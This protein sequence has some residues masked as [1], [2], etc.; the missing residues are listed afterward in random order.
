MLR[1]WSGVV[2][3][4]HWV[5]RIRGWRAELRG[6]ALTGWPVGGH[7]SVLVC[8]KGDCV[9]GRLLTEVHISI[10]S[11]HSR[12]TPSWTRA[13]KQPGPLPCRSCDS[14]A[15]G[16]LQR[17][18]WSAGGRERTGAGRRGWSWCVLREFASRR[19]SVLVTPGSHLVARTMLNDDPETKALYSKEQALH[20]LS[21][22]LRFRASDVPACVQVPQAATAEACLGAWASLPRMPALV[23]RPDW[24]D[25]GW[26]AA[27]WVVHGVC[28]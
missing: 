28:I 21:R 9:Q 10:G 23:A 20:T 12:D 8:V 7:R 19:R 3:A 26:I 14:T 24:R 2:L 5:T 11:R 22:Q 27:G 25:A 1:K 4:E 6:S 18:W 16:F 17:E 15:K 13:G